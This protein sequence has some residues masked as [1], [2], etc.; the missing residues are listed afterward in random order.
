MI[1]VI[2]GSH[3]IHASHKIRMVQ[4]MHEMYAMHRYIR[5]GSIH[6]VTRYDVFADSSCY[7]E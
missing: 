6:L 3:A 4:T 1:R 2:H 5:P 7:P